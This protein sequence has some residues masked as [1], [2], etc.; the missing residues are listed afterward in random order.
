MVAALGQ[1]LAR[2]PLSVRK[3]IEALLASGAIRTWLSANRSSPSLARISS[4]KVS[5]ELPRGHKAGCLLA[6][7]AR[8]KDRTAHPQSWPGVP[9]PK[10]LRV[11]V[12]NRRRLHRTRIAFDQGSNRAPIA[13]GWPGACSACFAFSRCA[14]T[15]SFTSIPSGRIGQIGRVVCVIFIVFNSAVRSRRPNQ[16]RWPRFFPDTKFLDR[17]SLPNNFCGTGSSPLSSHHCS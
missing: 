10:R 12:I 15:P 16:A 13:G 11:P 1:E 2:K 4:R 6:W 5:A 3:R 7:C 17:S 9:A 14:V 8:S